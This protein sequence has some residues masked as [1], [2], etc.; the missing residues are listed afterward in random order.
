MWIYLATDD[1]SYLQKAKSFSQNWGKLNQT[2]EIDYKWTQC[3]DDVH[4]GA[5]MLL[6][7]YDPTSDADFY[8]KEVEKNLDYWT[9]GINGNK[10]AYTP[11]GLAYLSEWGSLRYAT[12]AAF[13]ASIYVDWNGAD[14]SKAAAYEK[15]AKSQADYALGSTG[16]SYVIGVG[17]NSS[18]NSHHRTAHGTWD[19]NLNGALKEARHILAGALVGGPGA[20]DDY[21]DV[22]TDYQK[23]EVACDY[24]AGFTGLM[25][26]MYGD[27]NGTI[28]PSMNAVEAVEEEVFIE[29][30][31]N[32]QDKQNAINFIEIKA[33]VYNRTA[34]PARVTDKLTYRYFVDISDVLASGYKASDMKVTANY[35]QHGAKVSSLQPWDEKNG[36]YYVEVDMSGAKI[37]PGGQ[38]EHRSELQFRIAAP[39]KWDYTKSPSFVDIASASSGS[40]ARANH[41]ALYDNGEL[42]FGEEPQ[43]GVVAYAPITNIVNPVAGTTFK[44]VTEANPIVIKANAEVQES[45]ISKV[46]F[47]A[48]GT[49]IGESTEGPY[50]LNFVPSDSSTVVGVTKEYSLTVKATATNGKSTTSEAVKVSVALPVLAAPVVSMIEPINGTIIDMSKEI[51][52]ITM[53]ADATVDKSTIQK[54]IFY[55]DGNVVAESKTAPYVADYLPT[56]SASKLGELTSYTITAEAIAASGTKSISEPINV[57]VQLPVVAA[58]EVKIITPVDGEKFEEVTKQIEVSVSA[59]VSEDDIKNVEFYANGKKF[60]EGIEAID[61]VYTA[62]YEVEGTTTEIGKLTPVDFTAKATSTKGKTST[63]IPAKV[64]VQL[65]VVESPINDFEVEIT[66]TGSGQVSTNTLVNNF[67]LVHKGGSD[68]DLSKLEIRYYYTADGSEAQTVWCD[69]ASAQMNKAPWYVAYTGKVSGNVIKMN[70]EKEGADSYIQVKFND[71]EICSAGTVLEVATR[72][73]KSNWSNYDQ[74]NDHS[75]GNTS[76]VCVYYDGNLVAGIEP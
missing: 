39:G 18:R 72:T 64:Y 58:P 29:A 23:N 70:E 42:I 5:S 28:D 4:Y 31:I 76:K 65:E 34:W 33:V 17:E 20:N 30:G 19:N 61:G 73:A 45:S 12:T 10:V 40:M 52:A 46:E 38:S 71:K 1:E 54:V 15:F 14:Q 35:S 55:V 57:S 7:K 48:N 32:A 66:N 67:K 59:N 9:V 56:G 11:K 27:Y 37:Y 49:K 60:A 2:N 25:A 47:F 41:F 13:L 74:G 6:A 8:K 50:E 24:N 68:L 26:K 69:H 44:D 75:Y 53:K 3:W 43:S 63:S 22:I 16:H 51:T 36:V 62:T 21:A